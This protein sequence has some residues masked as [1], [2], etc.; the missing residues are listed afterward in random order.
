MTTLFFVNEEE[1][2]KGLEEVHISRIL[3]YIAETILLTPSLTGY[4]LSKT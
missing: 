1:I 3:Q 2:C 4:K